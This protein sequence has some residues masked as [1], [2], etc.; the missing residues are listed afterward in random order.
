M[1][2]DRRSEDCVLEL[3]RSHPAG[4]ICRNGKKKEHSEESL[5]HESSGNSVAQLI[6]AALSWRRRLAGCFA[7][8][9]D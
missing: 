3:S 7:I 5:Y 6:L 4:V 2:R 8:A 1:L 9:M